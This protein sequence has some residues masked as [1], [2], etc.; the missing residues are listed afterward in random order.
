MKSRKVFIKA[1]SAP[2]SLPLR[3]QVTKH[4]T[5]KWTIGTSWGENEFQPHVYLQALR[6]HFIFVE[7][8][9]TVLEPSSITAIICIIPKLS[10]VYV[11][12]KLPSKR[13]YFL[14][15]GNLLENVRLRGAV[16]IIR[17]SL[18]SQIC[19]SLKQK[20]ALY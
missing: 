2:A 18:C 12:I 11:D 5:V 9:P 10:G 7:G 16:L 20:N 1:R 3:G 15:L 14:A 6:S 4:T 17:H 13:K 8:H 19:Y